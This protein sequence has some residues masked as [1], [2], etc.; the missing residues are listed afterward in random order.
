MCT[1]CWCRSNRWRSPC[2]S[3]FGVD[4]RTR[5]LHQGGWQCRCTGL[6]GRSG[7]QSKIYL[8]NGKLNHITYPSRLQRAR[9]SFVQG[10]GGQGLLSDRTR[11]STVVVGEGRPRVGNA[12]KFELMQIATCSQCVLVHGGRLGRSNH[13]CGDHENKKQESGRVH[14][15]A[16]LHQM[17]VDGNTHTQRQCLY[18]HTRRCNSRM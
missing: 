17:N 5:E 13:G 18:Q 1:H 9:E 2:G 10:I 14:I 8:V 12:A 16:N 3:Q 7:R 6:C 15:W 4:C 11:E